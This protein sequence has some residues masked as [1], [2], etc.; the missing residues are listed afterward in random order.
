[1]YNNNITN[2]SLSTKIAN[3]WERAQT[4]TELI[5]PFLLNCVSY[6]P[7]SLNGT[8]YTVSRI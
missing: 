7:K 1:M 4:Y 5:R 8:K 2:K 3:A 6:N